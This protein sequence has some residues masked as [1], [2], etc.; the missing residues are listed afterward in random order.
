MSKMRKTQQSKTDKTLRCEKR[1]GNIRKSVC[2]AAT[3]HKNG[4]MECVYCATQ[5]WGAQFFNFVI[6]QNC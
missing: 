2:E 6:K 5:K 3:P 1:T 4:L